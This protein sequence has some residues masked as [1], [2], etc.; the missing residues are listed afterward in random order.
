MFDAHIL[1]YAYNNIDGDD[2]GVG[3]LN[4]KEQWVDRVNSWNENDG[5]KTRYTIEDWDDLDCQLDF[6]GIELAE[7]EP[8]GDNYLVTW[9]DKDNENCLEIDPKG[10]IVWQN[11]STKSLSIPRWVKRLK[12]TMKEHKKQ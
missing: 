8:N 7:V 1:Y 6:R 12:N 4:N 11:N 10:E 9:F 2:F 5:N 3:Y